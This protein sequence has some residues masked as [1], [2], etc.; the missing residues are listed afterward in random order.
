M[1]ARRSVWRI[2]IS[3][4]GLFGFLVLGFVGR[5]AGM[6]TEGRRNL[7]ADLK[8]LRKMAFGRLHHCGNLLNRFHALKVEIAKTGAGERIW[9]V[10]DWLL[11]P[12][13]LW[14]IDFEGLSRFLIEQMEQGRAFDRKFL[15]LL[16]LIA[17]P[18]SEETREV[19]GAFEHDVESG[20]YDKMLKQAQKYAEKE[21]G[22]LEN[23]ELQSK[24]NEIRELFGAEKYQSRRGVIRRRV[25]GERNFRE[26]WQFGWDDEAGRFKTVFDALCYRWNLYGMEKDKPLL[27][28]VTVNPTPYGTLIMIPRHQS[29]D[30]RRDLDWG[31]IGRLHRARGASRQGP[32]WS[33]GRVEKQ[34]EARKVRELI[35]EAKAKRIKGEALHEFICKEMKRDPASD[36]SWWKRLKRF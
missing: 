13:S 20:R 9:N 33:S 24:W 2:K 32:K 14:P 12:F 31:L 22:T 23:R 34:G 6:G 19:I 1:A 11:T 30:P 4:A 17:E 16:D 8:R 21:T 29:F 3:V 25:S 28:K 27:M 10:Y 15:V 35:T 7:E 5:L 36:A 18:P 26:G